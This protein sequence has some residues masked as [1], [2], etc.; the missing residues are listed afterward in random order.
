MY[1]SPLTIAINK[2]TQSMNYDLENQILEAVQQVGIHVNKEELVKA[3]NYDRG[4][5]EKGYEDAMRK[6]KNPP[7][8]EYEEI[9]EGM[10]VY[11]H[12]SD[13]VIKV[14]ETVCMPT[15]C[16]FSI[17]LR[18]VKYIGNS[19]LCATPYRRGRFYPVVIPFEEE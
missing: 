6:I 19:T 11:D 4:Q 13:T 12:Y 10:W 8:L 7:Y 16:D 14:D 15:D 1:E 9:K 17:P 5:Y 18:F 3:L 2:A